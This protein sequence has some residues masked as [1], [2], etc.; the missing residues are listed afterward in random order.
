MTTSRGRH[1]LEYPIDIDLRKVDPWSIDLASNGLV[2]T[3]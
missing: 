3:V 2:R 1:L